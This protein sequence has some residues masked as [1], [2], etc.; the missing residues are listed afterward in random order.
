MIYDFAPNYQTPNQLIHLI[1]QIRGQKQPSSAAKRIIRRLRG[2][3]GLLLAEHNQI[4]LLIPLIRGQKQSSSAARKSYPQITQIPRITISRA[5]TNNPLNPPNPR[6][7]KPQKYHQ[8]TDYF[9]P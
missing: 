2:L 5:P 9:C 3:H 1:P 6:T 4:I 8:P 7:T